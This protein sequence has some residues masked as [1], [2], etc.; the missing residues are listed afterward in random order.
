[1]RHPRSGSPRSPSWSTAQVV[2]DLHHL[3]LHRDLE[4]RHHRRRPGHV[5]A[6]ATDV[7]GDTATTAGQADT[8]SNAAS[9]NGNL[10]ANGTLA[11]NT[12][13]GSDPDCWEQGDTGTNTPAWSYT[14]NGP[15]GATPKRWRSPPT[16]AGPRSSSPPRRPAPAHPDHRGHRLHA[17]RVVQS[18]APTHILAYYPATPA[19][20]WQYWTESPAFAASTAGAQAAW[21]TPAVPAGCHRI[22]LRPQP[23]RRRHLDHRPLHHDRRSTDRPHRVADRARS[24]RNA[25]GA[26]DVRR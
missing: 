20:A 13:G 10:L 22:E 5:T 19:A 11:T 15:S 23:R 8:I 17:G 21:T 12:G 16:P 24:R 6:E 26:G 18:T 1:M 9:R 25:D 2:A 3:P 14:T 4:L 7:S